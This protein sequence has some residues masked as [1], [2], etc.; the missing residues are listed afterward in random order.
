MGWYFI[1]MLLFSRNKEVGNKV[2]TGNARQKCLNKSWEKLVDIPKKNKKLQLVLQQKVVLQ[3]MNGLKRRLT[4]QTFQIF[5]YGFCHF[6]KI[7]SQ[8]M[9]IKKTG[10]YKKIISICFPFLSFLSV[11][12]ILVFSL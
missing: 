6:K 10:S 8:L 12:F 1:D 7:I 4:C 3:K 9:L 2:R 5:I 11:E